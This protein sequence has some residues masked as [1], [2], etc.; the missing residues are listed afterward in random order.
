MANFD[1]DT[2]RD[3]LGYGAGRRP[4]DPG[5]TI[6]HAPGT[7]PQPLPGWGTPGEPVPGG[8]PAR[9]PIYGAVAD[10]YRSGL[11]REGSEAEINRWIADTGG[12]ARKIQAGIWGSPEAA[13]WAQRNAH[14]SVNAPAQAPASGGGPVNGDYRSWFMG[15][16]NGRAPTPQELAALGPLL[17]QHGVS[18]APNADGINGKI[19]LPSGEIVDVIKGAEGGGQA[20]QWLDNAWYARNGGGGSAYNAPNPF[21]DPATKGYVDFLQNRINALQQP[22]QNPELD[23]LLAYMGKYFEQLQQPV[24]TDAQRD[25]IQTQFSDPLERQRTAE[26]QRVLQQMA[27]RGM[28]PAD[29]PTIQALQDVDRQFDQMRTTG[30]RDFAANEINLGRENQRAAIDVGSQAAALRNGM[31]QQQDARSNQAVG[32]ARQIPDLAQARL[33]SAISLLNG[34]ELNPAQLF[35]TMNSFQQQDRYRQ[36]QDQEYW[37]GLIGQLAQIF[38]L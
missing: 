14:T 15:L 6:Y 16:T 5:G 4:T 30:Q 32:Y 25:V 31:F 8:Q 34:N 19:R 38:G 10:M 23:R 24:Y 29:G 28:G 36:Q 12:D 13:A 18:L 11:G 26:K 1:L 33:Q 3:N 9:S 37:T 22:Q 35:N 2:D 21:D 20:W 7:M 27:N 17:Q